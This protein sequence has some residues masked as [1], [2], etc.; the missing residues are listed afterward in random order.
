MPLHS[1]CVSSDCPCVI[2]SSA[3]GVTT[4]LQLQA[5]NYTADFVMLLPIDRPSDPLIRM[6]QLILSRISDGVI[7]GGIIDVPG[8]PVDIEVFPIANIILEDD[9]EC[10][11]LPQ[12]Q[13]TPYVGIA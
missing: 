9:G 6:F 7:V 12:T 10:L 11:I 13:L 3:T 2:S 1:L 4:S 5:G 8:S